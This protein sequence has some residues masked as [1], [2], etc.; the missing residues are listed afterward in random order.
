MAQTKT[1]GNNWAFVLLAYIGAVD[2]NL[3]VECHKA[4]DKT[5]PVLVAGMADEEKMRA[6]TLY[7]MLVQVPHKSALHKSA[8]MTLPKVTESQQR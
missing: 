3:A 6:T 8:L 5:E 4:T 1:T 2:A 7:K